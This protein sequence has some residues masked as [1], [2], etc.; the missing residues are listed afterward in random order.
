MRAVEQATLE[1]AK[2][3]DRAAM[4]AVLAEVAPTIQRFGARLCGRG[5]D[6]DDVVQ[7]TLLAV[8]SNLSRFEERASL[9]S[10]VFA[11]TRSACSRR[12]RG[13][14]NAQVPETL[15]VLDGA[16]AHDPS[17]EEAAERG[18]VD[19][20]VARALDRLPVDYREVLVLRDVEGLTAPEAAK[21]LGIG[22]DAL[23]S[24]LH[25]ARAALRAS[26][27]PL[28][29]GALEKASEREGCPDIAHVFSRKLEGELEASDCAE[30]ERH[31]VTCPRCARACDALREVVG[32][33]ARANAGPVP[34]EL[35]A[36][37]RERVRV[38]LGLWASGSSGASGAR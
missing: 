13:L 2:L 7:D 10:W 9:S 27:A 20:A 32:A 23:K 34:P 25:R 6:L 5:G 15:D 26:L 4:E 33:C 30:M 1:R 16:P 37:V 21:V 36:R 3:G 14:A 31:L 19:R 8:A 24:R 12:H 22:V 18:E 38:A 29:E 11:L 28:L 35:E 17:P